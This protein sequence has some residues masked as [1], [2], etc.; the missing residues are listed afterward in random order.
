MI[1]IVHLGLTVPYDEPR[2]CK[3]NAISSVFS[4]FSGKF[5]P[6]LGSGLNCLV[7]LLHTI[8]LHE[9]KR[10]VSQVI[11]VEESSEQLINCC[12]P[13]YMFFF[14]CYVRATR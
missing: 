2:G 6:P 1:K 14:I 9:E 12:P 5:P 4:A 13:Y 8:H 10:R 3:A 7:L 11:F